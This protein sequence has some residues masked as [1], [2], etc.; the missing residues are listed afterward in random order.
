[1]SVRLPTRIVFA[2]ALLAA[3]LPG[4]ARAEPVYVSN[5][6]DG[7][8][9][10]F[11]VIS[12][13]AL[14]PIACSPLTNC[15]TTGSS[16]QGAAVDPA[17]RFLY[18]AS[19]TP[20]S[21]SI[22]GI[23]GDGSLTP[24]PCSPATNCATGGDPFGL[25]VSPSGRYVYTANAVAASVSVFQVGANGTLAPIPCSPASNCSTGMD[26]AGVA[27]DPSGRF[28]YVVND[29]G[30][31]ISVFAV[32]ANGSLSPVSCDPLTNC[33][34]GSAPN[35]IKVTPSGRFLYVSNIS[36][37]NLSAYAI[38]AGGVLT[39]VP[40]NPSSRCATGLEPNDLAISPSGKFL[41]AT[42]YAASSVS[43]F[44][45]NGDG[46][47]APVTCDPTTVCKTGLGPD[48]VATSPA[49]SNLYV[50]D[51]SSNSVSVFGVKADGSLTPV[52]CDPSTNCKTG[53]GPNF[54]DVALPPDEGPT[55][56]ITAGAA[57]AGL[58]TSFD[59]SGSRDPD[60]Q[61]VRYDWNFG[62]GTVVQ[63]AGPSPQH[64]YS[65]PGSYD[66]SV[67]V[68]DELGCSTSIYTGQEASCNGA[69][70]TATVHVVAL[71]AKP[72]VS[73]VSQS[74]RR[75]REGPAL[76]HVARH[77]RAPRGTRFRFTLNEGAK[78]RFAFTQKR[79]GRRVG[80]RCVSGRKRGR[81]CKR[82]VTAGA[83]SFN[84]HLGVNS[85][86]FQGRISRHKRLK[87]GRYTL[88]VTATD[89]GGARSAR[90][91]VSF[92]IVKS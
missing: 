28:V 59:A 19:D 74:A 14:T 42:N 49:G 55:A 70:P 81:K 5:S 11:S 13:G 53:Q 6:S 2:L 20:P 3:V 67:T 31:S 91:S 83:L 9:S 78:V 76:P 51:G 32:Q 64:T 84:G 15:A 48:G 21:V 40:C 7:T 47:L 89:S 62:D 34:T 30:N 63:D 86:R 80:K 56:A 66:A 50:A 1:M 22:F 38:G 58:P 60:G 44:G 79:P 35:G 37:N 88:V 26:P 24:L 68:T 87:P 29:G 73:R 23:G 72:V 36:S 65:K 18:V 39:P 10:P 33:R 71:P 54:Q 17:G 25:A 92:T 85:V 41:Y 61:V 16:P 75:W 52:D 57:R 45:I 90:R 8:V 77:K 46:T 82:T 69:A 43:V 4:V 27:V 12:S